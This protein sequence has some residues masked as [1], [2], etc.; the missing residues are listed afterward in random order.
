MIDASPSA[1][2]GIPQVARSPEPVS[3]SGLTVELTAT[4]RLTA[5]FLRRHRILPF[6]I[7]QGVLQVVTPPRLEP[8][9]AHEVAFATGLPVILYEAAD[10]NLPALIDRAL[11]AIERGDERLSPQDASGAALAAGLAYI[12]DLGDAG[13]LGSG[14]GLSIGDI[15]DINAIASAAPASAPPPSAAPAPAPPPVAAPPPMAAP[16]SPVAP[17]VVSPPP[18][19]APA[20]MP[21]S[22][23]PGAGQLPQVVD[24][25]SDPAAAAGGS[26]GPSAIAPSAPVL[27]DDELVDDPDAGLLDDELVDDPDAGLLDDDLLEDEPAAG[28]R[29]GLRAL[30]L[31]PQ[32]PEGG[33]WKALLDRFGFDV[34]VA[35]SPS[36]LL[37][38]LPTLSAALV[39][40]HAHRGE[41]H[42]FELARR[43][44]RSGAAQ[45]PVLA[46]MMPPALAGWRTALD[47]ETS[48]GVDVALHPAWDEGMV[49]L[50]LERALQQRLGEQIRLRDEGDLRAA[51]EL[52]RRGTAAYKQ[53]QVEQAVSLFEAGLALD[54]HA[55]GLHVALAV[56]RV[57]Q[58]RPDEALVGFEQ[59]IAL[60]PRMGTALRS[61]AVLYE[62]RGFRNKAVD[63]WERTLHATEDPEKRNEILVRIQQMLERRPG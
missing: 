27:M 39:L 16:A 61:L 34:T 15:G 32:G 58:K 20:G 23:A 9:V 18:P 49:R 35:D 48:H 22:V 30:A 60:E 3:L 37:D 51:E 26:A 59:A 10:G 53:G 24:L 47:L 31:L 13:D 36:R 4:R 11:E 28:P 29:L 21:A 33:R 62:K 52:R 1:V 44:R 63:T 43:V 19:A 8:I 41:E 25:P 54:P 14:G 6:G 7:E 12:E 45:Q 50:Q 56:A 17:V 55:A 46:V 57:K 2:D 5:G 42:S 40:V 38:R